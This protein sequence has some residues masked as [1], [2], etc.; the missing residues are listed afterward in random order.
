MFSIKS[1]FIS[2]QTAPAAEPQPEAQP[3]PEFFREDFN[4]DTDRMTVKE[5]IGALRGQT[6]EFSSK[7]DLQSAITDFNYQGVKIRVKLTAA[8]DIVY[9]VN[10]KRVANAQ[11]AIAFVSEAVQF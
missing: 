1:L 6:V 9:L 4:W 5:L 7:H 8:Q 10:G 3:E 2:R 11:Q